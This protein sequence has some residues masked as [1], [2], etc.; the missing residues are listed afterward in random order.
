MHLTERHKLLWKELKTLLAQDDI[1]C[2]IWEFYGH[3]TPLDP[4]DGRTSGSRQRAGNGDHACVEVHPDDLSC[5]PDL[6][7]GETGNHPGTAGE[8][9]HA[10]ASL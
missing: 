4:H 1:D 8:I 10:V 9:Q 7:R 3:S 2:G 5:G 6:W